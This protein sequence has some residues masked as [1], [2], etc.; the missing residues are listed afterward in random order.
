MPPSLSLHASPGVFPKRFSVLLR[1]FPPGGSSWVWKRLIPD[2][3]EDDTN[4]TLLFHQPRIPAR[5]WTAEELTA[6]GYVTSEDELPEE[7]LPAPPQ[8]GGFLAKGS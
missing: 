7:D 3:E 4:P 2:K 8:V 1:D 6:A 5:P